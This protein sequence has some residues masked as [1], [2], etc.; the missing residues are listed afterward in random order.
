MLLL[1]SVEAARKSEWA[2]ER[3]GVGVREEGGQQTGASAHGQQH[4]RW[5][6]GRRGQCRGDAGGV[7]WESEFT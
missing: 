6:G 7:N 4:A 3:R 2:R 5:G 1:A